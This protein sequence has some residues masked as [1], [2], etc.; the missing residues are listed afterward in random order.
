MENEREEGQPASKIKNKSNYK[1]YRC[2]SSGPSV[3]YNT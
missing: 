3:H 1:E 2:N